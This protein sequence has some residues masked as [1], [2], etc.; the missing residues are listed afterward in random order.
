MQ[1]ILAVVGCGVVT[2]LSIWIGYVLCQ[3]R[4]RTAPANLYRAQ[5]ELRKFTAIVEQSPS[6]VLITDLEGRIEYVNPKFSALTVY[7]SEEVIGKTPSILGSGQTPRH[8]Y[9]D[10]WKTITAGKEWRGEFL[11]KKKNGDLYWEYVS[12]AGVADQHGNLTHYVAVKED[13]T[14]RKAFEAAL[15]ENEANTEAML[16]AIPD[17]VFRFNRDGVCLDVRGNVQQ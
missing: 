11:N 16:S 13:I 9:E 2:A 17:L 4:D 14:E 8:V 3:R 10:M 12:I 6:T 1:I 15:R 7:T 5:A